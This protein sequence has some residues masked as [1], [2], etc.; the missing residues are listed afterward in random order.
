MMQYFLSWRDGRA[1]ECVGLENRCVLT[2]TVGSNP[3]PSA[4]HLRCDR[5]G[6]Q[7]HDTK[8]RLTGMSKRASVA[9]LSVG[10][11]AVIFAAVAAVMASQQGQG[12]PTTMMGGA[13]AS[14]VTY[15]GSAAEKAPALDLQRLGGGQPVSLSGIGL[16]RQP[17]VVNFFAS[18][19][20][21]CQQELKAVAGVASEKVVR[22]VGVDTNDTSPST[23]RKMLRSVGASY[24][25]GIGGTAQADQFRAE[26]LPTTVFINGKG[27]IVAMALG[28]VTRSELQRWISEL[29]TG[30][31]L[32]Q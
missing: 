19:C 12:S 2:G 23:A 16:G 24:P 3:T 28:A 27:H 10:V 22:F 17:L 21:A 18:W 4:E 6:T 9:L 7:A 14:L 20:N 31:P 8:L 13:T 11:A 25:V 32:K 30:R 5:M 26:G 1:D 15:T 29:V